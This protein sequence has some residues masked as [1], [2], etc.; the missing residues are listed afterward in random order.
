[1]G[2]HRDV[3]PSKIASAI[4]C[5]MVVALWVAGCSTVVRPQSDVATDTT[6][7][8]ASDAPFD[9][10][11]NE[12]FDASDRVCDW[13]PR[14]DWRSETRVATITA[15]GRCPALV[16]VHGFPGSLDCGGFEACCDYP[17][18]CRFRAHVFFQDIRPNPCTGVPPC[19][20]PREATGEGCRCEN[21]TIRCMTQ[22]VLPF[23][24][25][26]DCYLLSRECRDSGPRE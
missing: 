16:E 11:A 6:V 10:I 4:G 12:P 7:G 8:A 13:G 18:S 2:K 26:S 19:Y 5:S 23:Q 17:P 25:C 3:G 14:E 1:M 9:A 24:I 21:G 15:D 22:Q 20:E